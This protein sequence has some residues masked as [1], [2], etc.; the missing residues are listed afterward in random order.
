MDIKTQKEVVNGVL[1]KIK[2][3]IDN[4]A[5]VAG[6]APRNW[7]YGELA[8]D[9]DLYMRSFCPLNGRLMAQLE[10]ALGFEIT[11]IQDVDTSNYTSGLSIEIVKLFSFKHLGVLFQIIVCNPNKEYSDFKTNV[12]DHIDI[13]LNRIYCD[14]Y[15]KWDTQSVKTKEFYEDFSGDTLT[16][17]EDCMTPDQLKHCLKNHLPKM[18]RYYPNHKLVIKS[19]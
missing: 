3:F 15:S 14:W 13:G 12:I 16:L 6:G 5:I 18:Q 11:Q 19:V 9:I 17:Y 4:E 8:N 10:N 1:S 2:L 7:E